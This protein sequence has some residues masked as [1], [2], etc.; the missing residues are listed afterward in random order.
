MR[1]GWDTLLWRFAT[2][3]GSEHS[4]RIHYLPRRE[5][6]AWRER[7]A[8]E[9]CAR[10]NFPAPR[11]E[12]VGEVGGLPAMVLSWCPGRP[13]LAFVEK[14]PWQVWRLG[15]LIGRTQAQLHAVPPPKEFLA[16]APAD[17]IGR[18]RDEYTDLAEHASSFGLAVTSLTH[19]DYHPLNIIS[20]GQVVTGVVD[21]A[22]AAAGDPRADLARTVITI[23]AAPAP[24]GPTRP[25]IDLLRRV[26]LRAYRAGYE[27]IA[28]PMPDYR[29]LMAWAGA[30]L[31]AEIELVI[32]KPNVWGTQEDVQ[33]FHRL[34]DVWAR[35][36]GV[37]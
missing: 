9:A 20:D 15:K 19:M 22:Y 29:P 21:W 25:L 7:L 6:F 33:K 36:A 3:D 5:E 11:V 37:R 16:S 31:L 14:K 27:G 12:T 2:P 26:V 35:R 1:G 10:A 17:W 8:M 28:G 18:V 32:D 24:P 13:I 34:V 23:L 30:T 4:L